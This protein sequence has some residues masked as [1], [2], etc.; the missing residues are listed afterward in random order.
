MKSSIAL[1]SLVVSLYGADAQL[2][3]ISCSS[4]K[5]V[6]KT[7]P[8]YIEMVPTTSKYAAKCCS[9]TSFPGSVP[10][11]PGC[12]NL[13]V[14]AYQADGATCMHHGTLTFDQA[15]KVCAD[16]GARM[17]TSTE[18]LLDCTRPAK[19]GLN[20]K[21]IW[22][23]GD[24]QPSA[25]PSALDTE[26]PSIAVSASPS[27]GKT[28]APSA[29]TPA[30]TAATPA[31]TVPVTSAPTPETDPCTACGHDGKLS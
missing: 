20:A 4:Q 23:E 16:Q 19:Y 25:T 14:S 3:E 18:N 29:A 30:P 22:S 7:S 2:A 5:C 6:D 13:F 26:M 11:D 17:C 15:T 8:P 9:F 1:A 10:A 21:K 27:L 24:N 31:P 12:G 28:T